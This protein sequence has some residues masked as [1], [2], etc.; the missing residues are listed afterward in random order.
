M[1]TSRPPSEWPKQAYRDGAVYLA[2][3]DGASNVEIR[4]YGKARLQRTSKQR[5]RVGRATQIAARRLRRRVVRRDTAIGTELSQAEL[6][7]DRG[8]IDGTTWD[9]VVR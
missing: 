3:A 2:E 8:D 4:E 1:T 6:H 9:G 5:H 7:V